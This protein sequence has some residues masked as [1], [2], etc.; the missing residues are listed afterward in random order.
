MEGR[1]LRC[2]E[3]RE[4]PA[5]PVARCVMAGRSQRLPAAVGV[6]PEERGLIGKSAS[7]S[8]CLSGRAGVRTGPF[9]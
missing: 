5:D 7:L 3:S 8:D 4:D 9:F 2:P 1:F 6:Q